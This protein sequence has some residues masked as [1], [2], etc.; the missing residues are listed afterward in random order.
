MKAK[1]AKDIIE[2]V[3]QELIAFRPQAEGLDNNIQKVKIL[4]DKIQKL[5]KISTNLDITSQK[6]SQPLG[7][8]V[9]SLQS[10]L[11]ELAIQ[12]DKLNSIVTVSVQKPG[13]ESAQAAQQRK[14]AI[15]SVISATQKAEQSLAEKRKRTTVFFQFAGG[16]RPQ[17]EALSDALKKADYIVPGE[18]REG[19]AAGKHQVR[20]FYTQDRVAAEN[21]AQDATRALRNLGYSISQV[22]NIEAKPFVS[23]SGKKPSQG[24]VELWLEIPSR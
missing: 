18:E 11:K 17:A 3:Q 20:Y 13:G 4:D 12:V 16:K 24:T 1:E 5:D 9:D 19:G 21:L 6:Y 22:P 8:S 14:A 10:Q 2:Q 15:Q 23:Y 7:S